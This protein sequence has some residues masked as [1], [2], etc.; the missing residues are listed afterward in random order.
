MK[1]P[2]INTY[3][4]VMEAD[5]YVRISDEM[6]IETDSDIEEGVEV[7]VRILTQDVLLDDIEESDFEGTIKDIKKRGIYYDVYIKVGDNVIVSSTSKVHHVGEETGIWI[8]KEKVLV[9]IE[10][11]EEVEPQ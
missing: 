11:E 5:K 3:S 2:G 7:V 10:K 9:S 8:K 1:K 6:I 4:G